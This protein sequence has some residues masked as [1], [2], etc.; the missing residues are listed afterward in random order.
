M[1]K[2]KKR[3]NDIRLETLAVLIEEF[4]ASSDLQSNGGKKSEKGARKAKASRCTMVKPEWN[5]S[6]VWRR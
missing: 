1:L 4:S 3:K 5:E 2:R 6:G